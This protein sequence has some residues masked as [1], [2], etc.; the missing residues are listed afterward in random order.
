MDKKSNKTRQKPV[1]KVNYVRAGRIKKR[2][3]RGNQFDR[4]EDTEFA[5]TSAK[6]FK[7]NPTEDIVIENNLE[8]CILD[9]Y[10]VFT[11]LA[12]FVICATCNEKVEFKKASPNG[13]SFKIA[14][15]CACPT[16]LIPSSRFAGKSYEI[17]RRLVVA[18]RLLGIGPKGIDMFCGIMDIGVG[19]S[20]NLFYSSLQNLHSA[21]EAVYNFVISKAVREEK[22][23]TMEENEGCDPTLLT[24][25]GDG[26][27]KKRGFASF[28]GITTLIGKY[29]K[30]VVD[31]VVKSAIC[32]SCKY[33]E[34]QQYIDPEGFEAWKELHEEECCKNH[35]GSTGKMEVDAVKEMFARSMEK[36]GVK[37]EKYIGD[38]DSKTFKAILT[39]DPY[40]G[41][42]T[43]VKKECVGHVQKRMGSRLRKVKKENK[44]IGG[45]GTGKLTDKLISELTTYYGLAIRRHPKSLEEM[46]K[47]VWATY[48][49]KVSTDEN[50][51]HQNCPTGESSWCTYQKAVA[52][53]NVDDFKHNY[54]PLNP[55]I[56]E[57]IKPVYEALS[58]DEL[59]SRCLGSETQN[60]NE[61]FN[62]IA[63]TFAP[64]HMHAGART[65]EIANYMATAI[66]ND[67]FQPILKI[68]RLMGIPIGN[69]AY[70]FALSRDELRLNRSE[71]Y[72]VDAS[73][74]GRIARRAQRAKDQSFFEE[75][76]GGLYGPGIAE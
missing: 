31:S 1:N 11:T 57:A 20:N 76:E 30:K 60:S 6:K 58:S 74:E 29:T 38:G 26:T 44:G 54:D 52:Q 35:E 34:S 21:A 69:Q 72:A 43:V 49:H 71:A 65:V 42:P 8:N 64:K 32:N 19:L 16:R 24:V 25:S 39:E 28:Y 7:N 18:M 50:P 61:G 56:A 62:S 51:Q 27:W 68:M 66:F 12:T 5:S 33:W 75:E 9:F 36:H 37:Y 17:N 63:W 70:N 2:K 40:D 55:K 23:A 45:K 15:N 22:E 14:V 48:F 13:V 4:L 10:S 46:K 47:A 41:D 59:L 53:G 3:F 67:G 73:K